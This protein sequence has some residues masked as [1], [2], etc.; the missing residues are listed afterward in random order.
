[1]N[2]I[3]TTN[4]QRLRTWQNPA[5]T[6]VPSQPQ[7]ETKDT[8]K[9]KQTHAAL[10]LSACVREFSNWAVNVPSLVGLLLALGGRCRCSTLF[11]RLLLLLASQSLLHANLWK[12]IRASACSKSIFFQKP[13]NSLSACQY[14]AGTAAAETGFEGLVQRHGDTPI[15]PET[16]KNKHQIGENVA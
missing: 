5:L 13:R 11:S 14:I 16:T 6:H 7:P 15:A 1:M 2:S 8:M 3:T 9:P 4:P 12:T 10:I